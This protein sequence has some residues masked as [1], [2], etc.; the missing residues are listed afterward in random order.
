[1]IMMFSH[2][3]FDS[4]ALQSLVWW[5]LR[6]TLLCAFACAYLAIARRA[7]PAIRH[8]I[9]VGGLA[10]IALLPLA[11]GLLPSWSLP[12]LHEP[13]VKVTDTSGPAVANNAAAWHS[14]P[15]TAS[16]VAARPAPIDAP[17][18][19]AATAP[20]E[21]LSVVHVDW[22]HI[23][24]IAYGLV[25]LL[26]L[27]RLRMALIGA[28]RFARRARP[29]G[30]ARI[31]LE[32]SR[33]RHALGLSRDVDVAVS[34][35]VVVPIAV[36]VF[37]PMVI[38]PEAATSWSRE[39]LSIV[40]LHE[41]AHVRRR[42]G[43]AIVFARVMGAILWFHPLVWTLARHVRRES[44]RACDDLVLAT[45]VRGSEY[46]GH[47]VSIARA[48]AGRAALT[49]SA[50]AFATRSTLEQRVASILSATT[51]RGRLSRRSLAATAV[52]AA[53]LFVGIAVAHPTSVVSAQMSP[54]EFIAVDSGNAPAARG[55]CTET[56]IRDLSHL[57]LS[58]SLKAAQEAQ[59]QVGTMSEFLSQYDVAD[60]SG[61]DAG[62]EWY[63]R[64]HDYYQRRRYEN[65]GD[66]YR[67][68]AEHDYNK[69][70]AL[71]NAGCSYAL[72]GEPDKAIDALR[73]ALDAG[74]DDP[75]MYATDEDLNSLRGKPA[76]T[77]LLADVMNGEEAQSRRQEARKEYDDLGGQSDADA[78]DWNSV[79]VDLLRVGDY[80]K[81]YDA[82]DRGFKTGGGEDA[83]YN[84]ACARA[85]AG[86]SKEAL[87]LLERAVK[88]G[89]VSP[90]HMVEDADLAPLHDQKRFDDIAGLASDL[91]LNNN[92][93]WNTIESVG[94]FW[95]KDDT[96]RWEKAVSHYESMARKHADV[97]RAWFNLGFVQLEAG[98][99]KTSASSFQKALDL[100]YQKPTTM[101]NLA[102]SS[103]QTGDMDAA[104]GWLDKAEKAGFD[105]KAHARGDEDLDPL[106]DDP[107]FDKYAKWWK[108]EMQHDHKGDKNK[109]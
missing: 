65:A 26:L 40:L 2:S 46:A 103:A 14:S 73:A 52:V 18:V 88:T 85:L 83:L 31:H 9:A 22:T 69:S 84:M 33:A 63:A 4:V 67:K 34:P 8:L 77:K 20:V 57:D 101:Y 19:S 78:G 13:A 104:F 6:A 7:R 3:L 44:E 74:F 80:D 42:D 106:R 60:N 28:G 49:G 39:R 38:L 35:D 43:L 11:S 10:S 70:T 50:L 58:A 94:R 79:G 81:A 64:A 93:G 54:F 41:M 17:P 71:Y 15:R 36:G 108:S 105:V 53:A 56:T 37:H 75:D 32:M 90:D 89:P 24:A 1:M 95:K 102:C 97:G 23:A 76:F 21:R 92:T 51:S 96:R 91:D 59:E 98:D 47:L 61:S 12:V 100:G 68:A 87:D 62:G 29:A 27:I 16:A 45:G 107:R 30:D 66:A 72:A 86:K 82:F 25:A 5:L 109:I 55:A 48:C 99:A